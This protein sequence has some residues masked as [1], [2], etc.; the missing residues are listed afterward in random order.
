MDL[1]V[2]TDDYEIFN[3]PSPSQ[4]MLKD[5]G[6]QRK[7]QHSLQELKPARKGRSWEAFST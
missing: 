4:D 3:Q 7:P 2:S 1:T 5:M 6:I